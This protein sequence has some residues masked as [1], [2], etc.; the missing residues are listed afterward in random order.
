MIKKNFTV[1]GIL[2][3]HS[4][5]PFERFNRPERHVRQVADRCGYEV[6]FTAAQLLLMN[7][8]SV[9]TG[10]LLSTRLS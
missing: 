9:L 4:I 5:Y 3:Q 10:F 7:S 8:F 2:C 6:E 1:A